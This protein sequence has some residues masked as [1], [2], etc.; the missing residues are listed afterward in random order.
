MWKRVVNSGST[1]KEGT[2]SGAGE[3]SIA[4]SESD[5]YEL[6]VYDNYY[7]GSSA[8]MYGHAYVNDA[9]VIDGAD[10]DNRWTTWV[11]YIAAGATVKFKATVNQNSGSVKYRIRNNLC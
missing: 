7:S 6:G 8:D 3:V 10:S 11:G 1:V 9:V 4:I 5:I 2:I